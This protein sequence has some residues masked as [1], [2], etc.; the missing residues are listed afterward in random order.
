[1]R[2]Q[3]YF[4]NWI[5]SSLP[6]HIKLSGVLQL[7]A[8][9]GDAG[10][11]RYYRLNTS[12][13]LIAV[14]SPPSKE[15]NAA[16]INISLFLQ[17]RGV[18]TPKIY[19]VNFEQG[20]MLLEDFG[21]RLFQDQLNT[22]NQSYRYDQA[23]SSLLEIQ[24]CPADTDVVTDFN[25][26][27]LAEELALFE[28]W[29]VTDLLGIT[30]NKTDRAVLKQL[31]ELL[32]ENAVQQPQVLVHSDYHCRNLMLLEDDQLGV[33]DFQDAMR[34]PITYDLVS[35][36]KDC[37]VRWPST[38]VEQRA[39]NFKQRLESDQAQGLCSDEQFLLWFDLMGLQRHI[40]VLGIFARLA[41]RDKK[42]GYLKDIP[43]VVRYTLEAADNYP[44]SAQFCDWFKRV[45]VPSLA[46]QSW[47]KEY[48]DT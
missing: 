46:G 44:Q 38:W 11:R 42:T 8:L 40:K 12:P 33:I 15:K 6:S 41:L 21:E 26:E 43:L 3:D 35:L 37:Y 22:E 10:F 30:L 4:S 28:R 25:H 29:F 31:F 32:I 48:R 13:S 9:A 2:A 23:E 20:F 34:G 17:S 16:Y 19:A 18:R 14:D 7:Q 1:M 45:I 47:Y 5:E 27:K 36:L 39:L 24:N